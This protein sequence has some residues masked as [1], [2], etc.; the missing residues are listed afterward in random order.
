ML[1]PVPCCVSA[2]LI[3]LNLVYPTRTIGPP[4]VKAGALWA[5]EP[6]TKHSPCSD[7]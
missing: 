6:R 5:G 3:I 4:P 1:A 7:H 2:R